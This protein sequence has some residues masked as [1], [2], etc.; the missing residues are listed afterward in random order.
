MDNTQDKIIQATIAWIE[1]DDYKNLS[2]RKLA[3]QIGMT[4]GA[5]YKYFQNKDELFYQVSIK[6]SQKFTEQ[7]ITTSDDSAQNE[8]LLLA[9]KFCQL[10][11][12][13]PHIINFLFFNSSL[14]SF[15][16]NPNHDFKFY[17]RIMELVQQVNRGGITDQQFFMQI[18][19]FI[20][21]Y[22]LLILN[23]AT[24]YDPILVAKTLDE[25][26]RGSKK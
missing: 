13:Q 10:S 5:I 25:I 14:N 9:N 26:I 17:N 11:Q 20:Q 21:G 3:T 16:K 2:M 1:T 22:S 23:G 6:L 24:G 15:Y 19:S 4:T 7:L 8:I 12:K 18:W